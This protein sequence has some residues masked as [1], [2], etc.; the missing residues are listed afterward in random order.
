MHIRLV[1]IAIV[2]IWLF[3]NR[4]CVYFWACCECYRFP[5]KLFSFFF[6]P[7]SLS[8]SSLTLSALLNTIVSLSARIFVC[9]R[10]KPKWH[11]SIFIC[12]KWFR[13]FVNLSSNEEKPVCTEHTHRLVSRCFFFTKEISIF[14]TVGMVYRFVLLSFLVCVSAL[15]RVQ[16]CRHI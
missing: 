8:L 9:G 1:F 2:F 3:S 4:V 16:K 6:L 13:R 14:Y 5:W 15:V 10:C 7:S 12:V 11:S